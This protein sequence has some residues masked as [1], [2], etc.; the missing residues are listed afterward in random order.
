MTLALVFFHGLMLVVCLVSIFSIYRSRN[1]RAVERS[2]LL[3]L[4]FICVIFLSGSLIPVDGFGRIQLIAWGVFLYFPVYLFGSCLILYH[5]SRL[6]AI[7]LGIG[8]VAVIGIAIDAFLIEP[9]QLEV[10]RVT[11]SSSKLD[12]SYKIVFLADLQT[13]KPGR[14]EAEVLALTASKQ[15]A[16][17]L[18]GG[19]YIHIHNPEDYQKTVLVLN[20]I[21]RQVQFNP[22]LGA[23]AVQGNV[24]W[25]NWMEIF[26][27]TDIE[28]SEI[29][30]TI[31]YGSL[32]LTT[33]NVGDSANTDL[34]LSGSEDFHL[35]LGHYPNFSLGDIDADLMLAGHTHG[36]QVQLP[37][38][39]PLLTL[40]AVPKKWASGVTEIDPNQHL[41]VSRGIGMERGYAPRMRFLCK[42]ELIII[43]LE[44][45]Q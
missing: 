12:R 35:V 4:I 6:Y 11:I 21:M 15:P 19:D 13:D 7:I 45:A 43:S 22:Q 28:V 42:P 20:S 30:R 8:F 32:S 33:L 23:Y 27:G 44:P 29:T 41:I 2:I 25:N 5:E 17:I 14:R 34:I 31:D 39:G 24:D 38:I 3:S 16:L 10:S 26:S 36:G 18:F 9:N 37:G 1:T 40:S